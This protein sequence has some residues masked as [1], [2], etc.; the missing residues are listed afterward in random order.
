M[1]KRTLIGLLVGLMLAGAAWGQ[2]ADDGAITINGGRNTILMRAPSQPFVP[3]SRIRSDRSSAF[4]LGGEHRVTRPGCRNR[5]RLGSIGDILG[6]LGAR[7]R[8]RPGPARAARLAVEWH[9][10]SGPDGA[11]P[12]ARV[13]PVADL[14]A[15]WA[16]D[17]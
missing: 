10:N 7:L 13:H 11:G 12:C 9:G 8:G 2:A 17:Q 6:A 14:A 5:Q 4:V 3:G 15:S 16:Q 1:T